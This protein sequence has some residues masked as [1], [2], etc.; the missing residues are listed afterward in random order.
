MTPRLA[1]RNDLPAVGE[2]VQTFDVAG[3]TVAQVARVSDS[4]HAIIVTYPNG[5]EGRW[6]PE[7]ITIGL[8]QTY[9]GMIWRTDVH[10]ASLA[11]QIQDHSRALAYIFAPKLT[12]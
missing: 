2:F 7:K 6:S 3:M 1:N 5:E 11:Q 10:Y 8:D 12:A 9:L 4:G